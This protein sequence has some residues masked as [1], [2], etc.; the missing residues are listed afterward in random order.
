AHKPNLACFLYLTNTLERS[1]IETVRKERGF[2][3]RKHVIAEWWIVDERLGIRIPPN[4]E[5]D[6]VRNG[7]CKDFGVRF[8]GFEKFVL[9][10]NLG[11]D[12]GI[13]S[14]LTH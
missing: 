7:L 6:V 1:I 2:A 12:V 5:G 14:P 11:E 4:T 8:N 9:E 3:M 10:V 13:I